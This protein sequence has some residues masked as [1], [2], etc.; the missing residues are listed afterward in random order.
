MHTMETDRLVDDYLRRLERAAAHMQRARRAELVAEIRGHIETALRQEQA[1][2]EA[3]VRNVLDRLGPPEDIVEAAE[4]PSPDADQRAGKLEITA[5][6]ALI[7]PFIGWLIGAVLVF[8][9]RIWSRRDK[10]IGALLLFLPIVLLGLGFV[11][12]GPSGS[13]DSTPPGANRPVGEKVEAPAPEAGPVAL[14]L[15]VAGLPSALYL[16]WQ[17]RRDPATS[18]TEP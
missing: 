4:P 10:L 8:A 14:V 6:V 5:L 13:E 18:P 15:F 1:A 16:G 2:G 12:A 7:V 3:A 9:S 17:L 11:A